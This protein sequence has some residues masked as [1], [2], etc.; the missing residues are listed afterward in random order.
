MLDVSEKWARYAEATVR[1]EDLVSSAGVQV[2][3]ILG[4]LG[5]AE[6][7]RVHAAVAARSLRAMRESSSNSHFWQGTPG[8]WRHL[9][10]TSHQRKLIN[11]L[12]KRLTRR[13]YTI[14]GGRFLTKWQAQRNWLHVAV[15]RHPHISRQEGGPD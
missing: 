15:P 8:L 4:V 7:G 3:N 13:G 9:L 6:E 12:G 11:A 5:E 2:A 10:P 14:E 1:Y